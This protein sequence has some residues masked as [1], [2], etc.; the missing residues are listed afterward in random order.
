MSLWPIIQILR[1]NLIYISEMIPNFSNQQK[2]AEFLRIRD[3]AANP[4][5]LPDWATQLDDE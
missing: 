4:R 3:Y 5:P 1:D 2:K